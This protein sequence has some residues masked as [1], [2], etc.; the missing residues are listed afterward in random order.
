MRFLHRIIPASLF[1]ICLTV[2]SSVLI[3]SCGFSSEPKT[4]SPEEMISGTLEQLDASDAVFIKTID[5]ENDAFLEYHSDSTGYTYRFVQSTGV[6]WSLNC[7]DSDS[8]DTTVSTFSVPLS[9]AERNETV[10]EFISSIFNDALIGELEII[11]ERDAGY[12]YKYIIREYY[13][14]METGSSAS[15]TCAYD[16]TVQ[17]CNVTFGT[18]FER[19]WDG[20]ITLRDDSPFIGEEAAIAIA[21]DEVE[22][23][24]AQRGCI[25]LPETAETAI[26]ASE[27]QQY[28]EV[29]VDTTQSDGYIVGYIVRVDVHSGEITFLV[30][31]Q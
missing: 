31:D 25:L 20:S 16:G 11:S 17:R 24:A 23:H 8:F 5:N 29:S 26:R 22:S 27:N 4:K 7:I 18:I 2:F 13:N 19:N 3:C 1:V 30:F 15:V 21:L 10:L 14:G 12:A 9:D 28:Y 6:L